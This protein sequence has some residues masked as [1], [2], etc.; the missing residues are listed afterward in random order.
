MNRR[1]PKVRP[2]VP[3]KKTLP[4]SE[5]LPFVKSE[6]KTSANPSEDDYTTVAHNEAEEGDTFEDTTTDDDFN[7]DYD[8]SEFTGDGQDTSED[9]SY[10]DDSITASAEATQE[11]TD[12]FANDENT[13]TA[14]TEGSQT[15]DDTDYDYSLTASADTIDSG[16]TA[17]FD[18]AE[19]SGFEGTA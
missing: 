2:T 13:I 7:F 5:Q 17:Y 14:S 18:D 10:F 11:T 6:E 1:E 3:P 15:S 19:N 4:P 12:E 16:D 8:T 9:D